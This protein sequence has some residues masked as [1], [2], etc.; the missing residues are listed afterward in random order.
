MNVEWWHLLLLLVVAIISYKV[1]YYMEG[2]KSRKE[3]KKQ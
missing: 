3:E 1:G 2:R